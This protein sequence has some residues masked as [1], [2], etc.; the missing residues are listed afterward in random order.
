MSDLLE[1]QARSFFKPLQMILDDYNL[2][3][4]K[5][6]SLAVAT[7]Y[8]SVA[9]RLLDRLETVFARDITLDY[10]DC[11]MCL[12]EPGQ[13]DQSNVEYAGESWGSILELVSG[14]V[15]LPS[16]PPFDNTT[17]DGLGIRD[18]Q[19]PCQQIDVD[20]PEEYRDHYARQ[21]RKTKATVQSWLSSQK[22]TAPDEID[23]ETLTFAMLTRLE[24]VK[25]PLFY[26]LLYGLEELPTPKSQPEPEDGMPR[27]I[28]KA[29][30][31]LQRLYRLPTLP[32]EQ[33]VVMWL[34][35]NPT[36]HD[37]LHSLAGITK[38]EWEILISGRFDGFLWS[39]A[40]E[41]VSS[42]P[43]VDLNPPRLPSRGPPGTFSP[44]LDPVHRLSF[45]PAPIQMDEE[46]EIAVLAEVEREIWKSMEELENA[47][48]HL[49]KSA[50]LVRIRL[51]HRS[52]GL[53]MAAQARRG[54]A[55]PGVFART[56]TPASA[57]GHRSA[58]PSDSLEDLRSEIGPDDSASNVSHNRRGGAHRRRA[59]HTPAPVEEEDEGEAKPPTLAQK[60]RRKF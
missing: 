21:S 57:F 10:C 4:D 34:I 50:E 54:D 8:Q 60:I 37:L 28:E 15:E 20:V 47:F 1:D 48:E 55:N 2:V 53:S 6:G 32:R 59:R 13:K 49:H 18:L 36:M 35:R 52:A 26:G 27:S 25:R 12:D 40:D 19:D 23:D 41:V 33:L 7:G 45:R 9:R 58:A 14:R 39:G 56:D 17:A 31:A 29:A 16:W 30:I 42:P 22:D 11:L 3:I 38:Q 43:G 44:P 46:T 51:R 24:Q 5:N